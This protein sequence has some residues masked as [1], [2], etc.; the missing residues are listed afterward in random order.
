MWRETLRCADIVIFYDTGCS[1]RQ[2]KIYGCKSG[3]G[4]GRRIRLSVMQNLRM[5]AALWNA[6]QDLLIIRMA[7]KGKADIEEM[8]IGT[9]SIR[10]S[11][12]L[13]VDLFHK[14]QFES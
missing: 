1:F 2:I 7:E 10:S 13:Q 8:R 14:Q 5:A 11:Y 6:I 3:K 4:F 12:D 9:F